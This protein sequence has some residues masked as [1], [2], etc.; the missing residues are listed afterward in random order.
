MRRSPEL[1]ET[2][3]SLATREMNAPSRPAPPLPLT[4][5]EKLLVRFVHTHTPEQL[6]AVD[7]AKW[8]A[9]DAREQAEFDRFFG[10][11]TKEQAAKAH[12]A[13]EKPTEEAL[14]KSGI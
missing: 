13:K 14:N 12:A 6:A 3:E 1:V 5:Q 9:Q 7:P 8:A 10:R 11:F 2:Q 4:D